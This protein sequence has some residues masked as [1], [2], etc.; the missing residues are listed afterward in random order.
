M[1]T[2]LT[3]T[4]TFERDRTTWLAYLALGHLAY[5]GTIPGPLMP[6]LTERFGRRRAFWSGAFR[7]GLGTTM[8]V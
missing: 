8:L 2:A 5:L 7:M 6:R 3:E 1:V 4:A